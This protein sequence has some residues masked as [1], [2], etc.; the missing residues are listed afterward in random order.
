[1][2]KVDGTLTQVGSYKRAE[3]K[4]C[5]ASLVGDSRGGTSSLKK[6]LDCHCVAY[7]G[8]LNYEHKEDGNQ[9]HIS[10]DLVDG[11]KRL[12]TRVWSQEACIDA[13]TK[14][15]VI[16]ELPFSAIERPGFRHFCDVAVPRFIPPCRKVIVK[17]FWRMYEEM[18]IE[19]KSELQSHQVCLTT[20]IW[21]SYQNINY[22]ERFWR[23]LI[24]WGIEKVLTISVDNAASNKIGIDYLRKR[25]M[26]WERK[27]ICAGMFSH[28]RCYAHT[29]NLVVKA[30]LKEMEKSIAAIRNAIR[31]VRSS[32][33]RTEAFKKCVEKDKIECKK[34]CIL[35]VPT[36]WNST[37]MMLEIALE[38]RKAFQRMADDDSL[39][40]NNYFDEEEE[41]DE[42]DDLDREGRCGRRRVGPPKDIDWDKA[43]CFVNFLRVFYQVTVNVSASLTPTAHTAFHDIVSVKAELDE[44]Y[45]RPVDE[46]STEVDIILYEMAEKMRKKFQKYYG[47]LDDINKLLLVAL[48]LD[49]HYKLKYF[50]RQA[51]TMMG[52]E[53]TE[54]RKK[55]DDL[56]NL[57]VNLCD[58][59]GIAIGANSL[60]KSTSF[61][62][63]GDAS[64]SKA[65]RIDNKV[66]GRGG[67]SGK[68]KEMLEDWDKQLEEGEDLVVGHEVDRYLLDP[69]EK[70]QGSKFDNCNW[71]RTNGDKYPS[72]QALARDVLAIQVST[73]A[74]ES[75]FSTGKRVIDPYRSSMTPKTVEALLCFQ[76]WLKSDSII[77]LEYFPT[78]EEV[79]FYE[80]I[81]KE[82][83]EEWSK[84]NDGIVAVMVL[85]EDPEVNPRAAKI[86]RTMKS[87]NASASNT[88]PPRDSTKTLKLK[89]VE[90]KRMRRPGFKKRAL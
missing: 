52:L 9:T 11:F 44:L 8:S 38:L 19:L 39:N 85:S 63:P 21:T 54:V 23:M 17:N 31:F 55:S 45:D 84:K 3:C 75:C 18:K 82:Q 36:R 25:M 12:T 80:T 28:V 89:S 14:M 4:H 1:M 87:S 51:E 77:G 62:S 43:G 33:A 6:H 15:I 86:G 67:V 13:A 48:V 40:Y 41:F 74:S 49:P 83:Q 2:E 24:E 56:K 57:L 61:S 47:S 30:G 7:P 72:L 90:R 37:Y 78:I 29:V 79:E 46:S 50:E 88:Q 22:M 58:L 73:V 81:E 34:I 60:H 69:I 53:K 27:P 16:D 26:G 5:H 59:Y 65:K 71:W 10:S 68:K 35:D 76:N 64:G 42:E 66:K 20:D 32:P 70:S